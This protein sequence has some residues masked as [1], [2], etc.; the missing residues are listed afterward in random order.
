MR[1]RMHTATIWNRISGEWVESSD[2]WKCRLQP[3]SA[4]VNLQK[5]RYPESTHLAIGGNTPAIQE[6]MK[7][8][9]DDIA[10]YVK[11]RQ[12]MQRPGYGAFSQEVYLTQSEA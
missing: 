8:V 2:I 12:D 6:G 10:Y 3:I 7:L 4:Q 11:G 9:I 5:T 1:G